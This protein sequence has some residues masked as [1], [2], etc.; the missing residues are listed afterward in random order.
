MQGSPFDNQGRSDNID[1]TVQNMDNQRYADHVLSNYHLGVSSGQHE[2]IALQQAS[3]MYSGTAAGLGLNGDIID[4]DSKLVVRTEQDR[5][6]EKLQLFQRPFITVPYMGRGF[7]QPELE[8]QLLQGEQTNQL[9]SVAT[10]MESSFLP[11]SIYPTDQN[12]RE[13][14]SDTRFTVEE[15]A[16]NGW[17]RGG[18]I[19]RD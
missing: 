10:I 19:T 2:D 11:L 13:H 1:T 5:A 9:K 6:L 4:F 15:A 12:M 8:A 3:V 7:C 17:V 16:L 14:V 18:S